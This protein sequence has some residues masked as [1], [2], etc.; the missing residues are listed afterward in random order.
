MRRSNKPRRVSRISTAL[1]SLRRKRALAACPFAP[2]AGRR[3]RQGDEGQTRVRKSPH[4]SPA[5]LPRHGDEIRSLAGL[6]P[7]FGI[8]DRE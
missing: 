5:P 1:K 4:S 6:Q 7:R 2:L 3:S 8:G